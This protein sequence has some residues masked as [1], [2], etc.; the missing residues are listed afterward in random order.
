ML[1]FYITKNQMVTSPPKAPVFRES[2]GVIPGM[3]KKILT[4]LFIQQLFDFEYPEKI[5]NFTQPPNHHTMKFFRFLLLAG[6]LF[7]LSA[8][9]N[10]SGEDSTLYSWE[11]PHAAILPNGDLQ[12]APE[13]FVYTPG[14]TVRYIDYESGNDSHDGTTKDTP[15]K[16]HPWD[17]E[18]TGNAAGASGIDTYVFKRG[19]VYRGT[20]EAQESGTAENPIRLTS[21][22]DWGTGEACFFGSKRITGGWSR[23]SQFS[24]PGMP[25]PDKIWYLN[26]DE[27]LPPT[28]V[29]CEWKDGEL[30][31]IRLARTPNWE[32]TDSINPMDGWWEWTG[33]VGNETQD[34]YYIDDNHLTQSDANYWVGGTVWSEWEGIMGALWG[35]E[36]LSFNPST[37]SITANHTFGGKGCRY[38]IEN[39]SYLLDTT[40][41]YYLHRSSSAPDR[42]YIRLPEDRNPNDAVIEMAVKKTPVLIA[43]RHHISVSGLSFACNTFDGYH[44]TNADAENIAS[45][46]KLE[47]SCHH[48]EIA[49]CRFRYVTAGVAGLNS[50]GDMRNITIRD[51]DFLVVDDQTI[52]FGSN[53][54]QPYMKGIRIMRNRIHDSGGRQLC[55]WYSAIPA[56]YGQFRTA[57]AAG[58]IVS[59]SWGAG[60]DFTW[61][62]P[63]GD[64]VTNVPLVCGL[65]HHNRVENTFLGVQDYGALESWQGGP[66]YYY[67]NYS[68]NARGYSA[69][70]GNVRWNPWAFP[71]Y[72]DG[73]FKNYVF[74][75]IAVG[76]FN[77]MTDAKKRNRLAFQQVLGFYVTWA[78]N[79]AYK[80]YMGTKAH[81]HSGGT[82]G[83][84][85]YLG[86]IFD[87][88]SRKYIENNSLPEELVPFE[89]YGYN[90]F[91]GDPEE[92]GTFV[93]DRNFNGLDEFR[94][95]LASHNAQL[96]QTGWDATGD[97]LTDP[98][99]NDFRPLPGGEAIDRGVRFFAP[100]SLYAVTGEWHFYEHPDD[101]TIIMGENFYFTG[102]F[103]NRGDYLYVPRNHL[104]AP[105]AGT[106]NFIMGKLENWTRGAFVFDGQT[107]Y[108]YVS[109]EKSSQNKCNDLNMTT[110]DFIVET[111]V[112]T[113]SAFTGGTVVSKY[114]E[115]GGGYKLEVDAD[116]NACGLIITGGSE[117]FTQSSSVAVNDGTWH[118]VLAEFDRSSGISMYIDGELQNGN[119]SGT[120]PVSSVSLA[121]TSDFLVGKDHDGHYFAGAMDF[122]R[123]SKGTLSAAGTT[124]RELY[125]WE[126]DG[127]FLYDFAGNGV[128]GRRD[129]GALENGQKDCLLEI[130][131]QYLEFR[132]EGGKVTFFV[133]T[134]GEFTVETGYPDWFSVSKNVDSIRVS[135]TENGSGDSRSGQFTIS[136]CDDELIIRVAQTL[137]HT[138]IKP[139][140]E[141]TDFIRLY[142]NPADEFVI[143]SSDL[144]QSQGKS[145]QIEILD[146]LGQILWRSRI[147][148]NPGEID[149]SGI[150]PGV[151]FVRVRTPDRQSIRKLLVR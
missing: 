70:G 38:Y 73:A 40:N 1:I 101:Y 34:G 120:L 62:K 103:K 95:S 67:N 132:G 138:G 128:L 149:I 96:D 92:F 139:L 68:K 23:G 19:S 94:A 140:R 125:K 8:G 81:K 63:S 49:N 61:G 124:I 85:F 41:E 122:L 111:F 82:P 84:N 144:E 136:S 6:S 56:V 30:E 31:R 129:A 74:N 45:F 79:T 35:Q 135:V 143:V 145:A 2:K 65:V 36:I 83:Y 127:P 110:H 151:Y 58:N 52:T 10:G 59:Y 4:C 27:D 39:L 42:L 28:K 78:N 148:R 17:P 55:R 137:S 130:I 131:D 57:E 126:T 12:W 15:W 100:L 71:Y 77:S 114:D 123:I 113:D 91:H 50:K 24:A 53:S 9:M 134:P 16:H 109:H 75:N 88:I 147:I 112:K 66:A 32:I 7:A 86:N 14:T 97:I 18:A 102:D 98:G 121:N 69:A 44:W 87:D 60:L 141:R 116:G 93:D 26:F 37:N 47:G 119:S 107:D 104:T 72:L 117:A 11:N 25:E 20:I 5:D 3:R 54:S 106:D 51:N 118:H 29:V 150:P 76:L 80:F 90:I 115:G 89:S 108:C 105:G 46:I 133:N 146:L 64:G 43:D 33:V 21:D 13:P 48:I 142:P 99:N 22:P